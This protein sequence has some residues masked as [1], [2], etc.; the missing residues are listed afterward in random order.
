MR[1]RAFTRGLALL[2][3]AYG[4]ATWW[5]FTRSAPLVSARPVTIRL[6][7]WQ[8]EKGPPDGLAAVI[9]RYEEINP[10]VK[11]EAVGVPSPIYRQW[12][13]TNLTGGTGTDIVEFAYFLGGVGDVP[14][15]YFE[16]LTRFM[17]I[18]NPYNRGTKMEQIPWRRT[19]ADNL[20]LMVSQSP[21]IGQIY[22]VTLTQGS[23]RLF[24]NRAL[25]KEITGATIPP[26]NFL[27]FRALWAQVAD[28]AKRT[29]RPLHTL[30]GSRSNA[31]WLLEMLMQ[32]CVTRL[33]LEL[34]R[35][36]CLSRN[37]PQVLED[38]LN[39]RWSAKG[40][41]LRAAY[42]LMREVCLQMRPGFAQLSR[43][44]A[45]QEFVRGEALFIFSGSFD[46][47][48]LRELAP[49]PVE[50][51][52]LPQ[53][54]QDDPVVGPFIKGPFLEGLLGTGCEFYL[55]KNT[56][57]KEEALDFLRFLTSVEG[58]QIFT[59]RSGWLSSIR[60]VPTP[61]ELEVQRAEFNGY[62]TG[63][64]Y[65]GM[66]PN[67]EIAFKQNFHLLVTP[68][69]SVDRFVEALEA[70]MKAALTEDLR[71]D[72]HNRLAGVRAVDSEIIAMSALNRVLAVSPERASRQQTLA[73]N[74][75]L[76]E[77]RALESAWILARRGAPNSSH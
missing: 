52:H 37:S 56:R 50:A 25:L 24:C 19:F 45:I 30:A 34:D 51:M 23:M 67:S 32:G 27:E 69:G 47:T 55:N 42:A 66:G 68:Q 73:A 58:G 5:V 26:K 17:E 21:E 44:D 29:G 36:G 61:P 60:S 38:Y 7:H 65:M 10:R 54:T 70:N 43:D 3:V 33:N 22:G 39:G 13:R 35:D 31:Q 75:T 9:K 48:S 15:R 59:E 77:Q 6:A 8:I 63:I 49:F 1:R 40:P 64:F 76:A 57:H 72:L 14:V 12:L 74:Q 28:H 16:P 53:L 71:L 2:I 41:D 46:A 20:Y 4:F 18:P 11:V 62:Y